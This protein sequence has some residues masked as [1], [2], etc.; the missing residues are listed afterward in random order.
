[1]W[2]SS[3]KAEHQSEHAAVGASLLSVQDIFH[4]FMFGALMMSFLIQPSKQ[5]FSME[6]AGQDSP[7]SSFIF[8]CSVFVKTGGVMT[9]CSHVAVSEDD[10]EPA[11][12][13]QRLH[14][15]LLAGRLFMSFFWGCCRCC[16][17]QHRHT[18][19][20]SWGLDMR[21]SW[22]VWNKCITSE[23]PV[24]AQNANS[25]KRGLL[26]KS[27]PALVECDYDVTMFIPGF[28][29]LIVT[30]SVWG[31]QLSVAVL[32]PK[33]CAVSVSTVVTDVLNH[34]AGEPCS[35]Q[36][37]IRPGLYVCH[38]SRWCA[39]SRTNDMMSTPTRRSSSSDHK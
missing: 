17:I 19:V 11:C 31:H 21:S 24:L 10:N 36:P 39:E 3:F 35:L 30:W 14:S 8:E 25:F 38:V 16:Q 33:S 37:S 28:V 7:V 32:S 26:M 2:T 15:F 22:N 34:A 6:M 29:E 20:T 23:P 9:N 5:I 12:S 1:M 4:V 27:P 13:S 18:S